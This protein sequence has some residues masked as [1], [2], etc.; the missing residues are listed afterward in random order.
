[1]SRKIRLPISA[2]DL[3]A[4][5]TKLQ[6]AE[7]SLVAANT[8]LEDVRKQLAERDQTLQ[9]TTAELKAK[10]ELLDRATHDAEKQKLQHSVN[11]Q[12]SQ[13]LN[14]Q[15]SALLKER[16]ELDAKLDDERRI[17]VEKT[18]QLTSVEAQ[19]EAAK[20]QIEELTGRVDGLTAES[21]AL[22]RFRDQESRHRASLEAQLTVEQ[23]RVQQLTKQLAE[24]ETNRSH[25]EFKLDEERQSAARGMELLMR[26]QE[27]FS[28]VLTPVNG[29]VRNGE[30]RHLAVDSP[31]G[32]AESASEPV[33]AVEHVPASAD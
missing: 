2:G 26:A 17:T 13:E 23:E 8:S 19:F 7:S 21:A 29:E 6:T 1:M 32:I 3:G 20:R 30:I 33:E 24:L 11:E 31:V 12:L 9:Q 27:N 22:S 14:T 10:T 25:L 16:N 28:R 15:N 4:L 5:R 18:R